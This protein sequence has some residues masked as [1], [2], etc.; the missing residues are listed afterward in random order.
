MTDEGD[1]V[2]KNRS[3]FDSRRRELALP[4]VVASLI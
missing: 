3:M 1:D 2:A 4:Y